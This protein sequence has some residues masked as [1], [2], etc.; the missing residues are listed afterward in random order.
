MY[1]A[2]TTDP[3]GRAQARLT[4]EGNPVN[5]IITI[6]SSSGNLPNQTISC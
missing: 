3:S 6:T 4:T 1:L 5:R 2:G